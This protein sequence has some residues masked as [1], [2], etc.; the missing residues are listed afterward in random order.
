[1]HISNACLVDSKNASLFATVNGV[2]LA[3][4][5]FGTD[6]VRHQKLNLRFDLAIDTCILEVE[7]GTIHITG[8]LEDVEGMEDLPSDDEEME[9]EMQKEEAMEAERAAKTAEK[10]K[11]ANKQLEVEKAKQEAAQKKAEEAKKSEEAK[12]KKA[13]AAKKVEAEKAAKKKAELEKKA[14]AEK[15]AKKADGDFIA[16]KKFAGAKAGYVFKKDK[17][18]VGY[19]KDN[20][21]AP[22]SLKR[23]A[24]DEG[25]K[26]GKKVLTLAGGVKAEVIK[27]GSGPKCTKGKNV[28]VK[29][30]G[31]LTNGNRFDKGSIKFRLG[32]GEVIKGW[33]VGVEGMTVGEK[34]KLMIPPAF[35][36]GRRGAPP[37]IPPQAT[38]V[39]DVELVR[40]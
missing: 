27:T 17:K 6:S 4:A 5:V 39:F 26:D 7:H 34:R 25:K 40:F 30:D 8:F 2:K 3:I 15:T 18:G 20:Y 36:Y 12:A 28:T 23:K 19:Y 10:V 35:A 29:Y 32:G 33:D 11:A 13:E 37:D 14:V 22:K 24:E 21:V 1:M 9:A 31:R 16:S 38:L